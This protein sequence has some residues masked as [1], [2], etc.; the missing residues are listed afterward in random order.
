[1]DLQLGQRKKEDMTGDN[2]SQDLGGADPLE[3]ER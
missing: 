1:M 2:V 3:S